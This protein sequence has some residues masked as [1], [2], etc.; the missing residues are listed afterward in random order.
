MKKLLP[1][2]LLS[3]TGIYLSA[4][5]AAGNRH[6]NPNDDA[7]ESYTDSELLYAMKQLASNLLRDSLSYTPSI[8]T[9]PTLEKEEVAQ[10]I[11]TKL[12]GLP[13]AALTLFEHQML[14]S[15][16][17]LSD[18]DKKNPGYL[19]IPRVLELLSEKKS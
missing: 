18:D 1:L 2:L 6:N 4:G 15:I 3:C 16:H 5:E 11:A 12:F 8:Q 7:S 13:P 14:Q 19:V 9:N 17:Q 10:E